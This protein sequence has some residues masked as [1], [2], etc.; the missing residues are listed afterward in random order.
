LRRGTRLLLL[1][2]LAG[3]AVA[4]PSPPPLPFPVL[5]AYG[6][7]HL[8]I[9]LRAP[10]GTPVLAAADGTVLVAAE[11]S[12]AGRM[13]V[14]AH[15]GDVASV[16][17]HLSEIAVAVGQPVR[18]GEPIGRT[19]MTGNATTP[20]L[21]FAV[22]RRP[23]GRCGGG[24]DNGWD[25]PASYWIEGNPCFEPARAYAGQPVRLTY[26]LPCASAVSS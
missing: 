8:G 7:R 20:H 2:G 26:P 9:D 13:I 4:P 12:R 25:D 23:G 18:R 10:V 5:T 6:P 3:C 17:M 24:T 21:H 11:R 1:V 22:C 14:L 16:Y 19:G 15:A